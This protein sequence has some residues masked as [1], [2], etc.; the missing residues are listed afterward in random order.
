VP[1]RFPAYY[2]L[3]AP[4]VQPTPPPQKRPRLD[5]ARY[6]ENAER[7]GHESLRDLAAEYGVSQV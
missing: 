7:A 3:D 2:P 1:F 6:P 4:L 5:P